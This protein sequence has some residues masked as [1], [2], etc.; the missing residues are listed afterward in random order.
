MVKTVI[1]H[2][3][4]I[5]SSPILSI[6]NLRYSSMVRALNFDFN[7]EGSNPSISRMYKNNTNLI[8]IINGF[9]IGLNVILNNIFKK[10][11]KKINLKPDFFLELEVT[12][13]QFYVL[14]FFLKKH[15]L[16]SYNIL[17]DL[18]CFELIHTK[19]RYIL[20]YNLLNINTGMRLAV[21]TKFKE[22]NKNLLSVT[23][24]FYTAN[25]SER[26]VY[27]FYGLF[28][29][30][31]KDLRR[32]LLDYGFK[33]YPLRKDFPLS[34]FL[35]LFYDD[36]IKKIVYDKITLCQE[37]RIFFYNKNAISALNK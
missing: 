36:T 6:R 31:N 30:L 35:E 26:E 27:D 21:K 9:R 3:T 4:I 20:V 17:I 22:L 2:I 33:G 18:V 24:L 29:Y 12:S 13:K 7:N 16:C 23:T 28:F 11:I 14:L 19:F 15:S 8:K 5:G 32:I 37:Y 1:L 34:G 25:W 10:N